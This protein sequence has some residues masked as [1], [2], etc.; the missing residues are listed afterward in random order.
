MGTI[1]A[2]EI[3]RDMG[4]IDDDDDFDF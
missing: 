1:A 3:L 4:G 2:R